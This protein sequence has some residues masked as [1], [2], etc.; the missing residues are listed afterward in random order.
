LKLKRML[1]AG[2]INQLRGVVDVYYWKGIP[3]ARAWPKKPQ[4]PGTPAQSATW[5]AFRDFRDWK[6]ALPSGVVKRW[7]EQPVPSN[8]TYQDLLKSMGLKL[9]YAHALTP[10][11]NVDGV[12]MLPP[13]ALDV[14]PFIVH[15]TPQEGF[16]PS[17]ILWFCRPLLDG[18]PF[19]TWNRAGIRVRRNNYADQMWRPNLARFVLPNQQGWYPDESLYR[20]RVDTDAR[21]V[22]FYARSAA[23]ASRELMLSPVYVVHR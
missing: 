8:K 1:D 22:A 7:R 14:F 11:P 10:P 19:L 18:E 12:Q 16:D 5:Q 17:K 3:V 15:V 20:L 13:I 9:S 6:R 4:Q 2:L 23:A 21:A